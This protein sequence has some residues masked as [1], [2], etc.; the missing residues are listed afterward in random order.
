V[1]AIVEL[2][3]GCFVSSIGLEEWLVEFYDNIGGL[4]SGSQKYHSLRASSTGDNL[5]RHSGIR[6]IPR[7]LVGFGQWLQIMNFEE[8]ILRNT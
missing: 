2:D 8:H 3:L 1:A 5:G 6:W 7:K 4:V